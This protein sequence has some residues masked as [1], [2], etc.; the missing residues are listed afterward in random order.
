MRFECKPCDL[1]FFEVAPFRMVTDIILPAPPLKVFLALADSPSYAR[2]YK[3][4]SRITWTSQQPSM[5]GATR[6]VTVKEFGVP[7]SVRERFIAWDEG[8]RFAFSMEALSLPLL[9]SGGEDYRLGQLGEDQSRLLWIFCYEPKLVI[10]LT[11]PFV[12][13]FFQQQFQRAAE[14]L[15]EYLRSQG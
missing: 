1:E 6:E 10:R 2:W 9:V 15:A 11:H 3:E 8:R 5:L 7:L 13:W 4:V 14:R 12:R